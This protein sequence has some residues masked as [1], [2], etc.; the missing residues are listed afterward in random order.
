[1]IWQLIVGVALI[2]G[3]G[4]ADWLDVGAGVTQYMLGEP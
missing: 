4:I 2:Y 3:G 1:M